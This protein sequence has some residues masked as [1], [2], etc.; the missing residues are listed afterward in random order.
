[1]EG[2]AAAFPLHDSCTL[3]LAPPTYPLFIIIIIRKGRGNPL[4]LKKIHSF[5]N[6]LST[7]SVLSTILGAEDTAIKQTFISQ[8]RTKVVSGLSS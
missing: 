6:L 3:P 8:G 2:L 4:L 5:N 7:Y 1:M